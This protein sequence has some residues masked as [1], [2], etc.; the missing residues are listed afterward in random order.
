MLNH[1]AKCDALNPISLQLIKGRSKEL[2]TA[3]DWMELYD[4]LTRTFWHLSKAS[5][6]NESDEAGMALTTWQAPSAFCSQLLRCHLC[7]ATYQDRSSYN[8]HMLAD[9]AWYCPCCDAK[10]IFL[11]FPICTVCGNEVLTGKEENE[12]AVSICNTKYAYTTHE[13]EY[14]YPKQNGPRSK[15]QGVGCWNGH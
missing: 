13:L 1:P 7:R 14:M 8:Q 15:A 2:E 11:D 5:N 10:N 6:S 3:G 4:P 9:H 12:Q